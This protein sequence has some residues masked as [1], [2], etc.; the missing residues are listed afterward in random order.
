MSRTYEIY[1]AQSGNSQRYRI[2]AASPSDALRAAMRVHAGA[3][4]EIRRVY[5]SRNK[6][7]GRYV[8]HLRGFAFR[9]N[10]WQRQGACSR[11]VWYMA[12]LRAARV[13]SLAMEIRK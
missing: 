10:T 6:R 4:V 1:A 8:G 11:R 7:E 12:S 2:H 5:E 9:S 13:W 3:Y